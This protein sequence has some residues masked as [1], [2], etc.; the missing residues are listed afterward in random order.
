MAI[1]N[2]YTKG[3]IYRLINTIDE[4]EYVGSTCN[5]LS[6]RFFMHKRKSAERPNIKVYQHL[7]RVGW[8]NTK[9]VLIEEFSCNS[10]MELERRETHWV[11]ELKPSL[12]CKIPRRT[13]KER[14]DEIKETLAEK[15]K[16]YREANRDRLAEKKKEYYENNKEAIAEYKRQYQQANKEAIAER[17]REAYARNVEANREAINAKQRENYAKRQAKKAQ[18]NQSN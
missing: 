12:N 13:Q 11:R 18:P 17:K 7:N 14:Y 2:R 8:E 16:K 15:K 3:K 9:I 4:A 6:K 1:E 5:E 10:K